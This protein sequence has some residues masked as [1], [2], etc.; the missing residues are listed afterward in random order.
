MVL[1]NSCGI[2]AYHEFFIFNTGN[3]PFDPTTINTS[4]SNGA[5]PPALPPSASNYIGVG[6]PAV[7]SIVAQLNAWAGCA[8]F[9]VAPNPIPPNSPVMAFNSSVAASAPGGLSSMT[10]IPNLSSYCGRTTYVV[11]GN[12]AGAA[13]YF[14]NTQ[15]GNPLIIKFGGC[16]TTITYGVPISQTDGTYITCAGNQV[17]Q[18]NTGA[19]CFPPGCVSPTLTATVSGGPCVTPSQTVNFTTTTN[20]P[21]GSTYMWTGPNGYNSTLANP[22]VSG[23]PAGN[24]IF[25]VK[26]IAPGGCFS[27]STV[28]VTVSPAFNFTPLPDL[29]VCGNS[30]LSLSVGGSPGPSAGAGYLWNGAGLSSIFA[31][32]PTL[33]PQLPVSPATGTTN[34]YSVTITE[35]NGCRWLDTFKLT[36]VPMPPMLSVAN[37]VNL[38]TGQALNL[39][40]NSATMNWNGPISIPSAPNPKLPIPVKFTWTG[41]NGFTTNQTTDILPNLTSVPGAQIPGVGGPYIYKLTPSIPGYSHP[42]CSMSPIDVT[43]NVQP[44]GSI[45]LAPT[46]LCQGQTVDLT[47]LITSPSP[48][49]VGSWTGTGVG[50]SPT[51]NAG[52]LSPGSYS[53]TFT[54]SAAACLAATSTNVS[55]STPPNVTLSQSGTICGLTAPFSGQTAITATAGFTTY[56]WSTGVSGSGNAVTVSAPGTYTVTVTNASGCT[57]V[58]SLT[59]SSF[60]SP[61]VS[62]TGPGSLCSGVNATL[63]LNSSFSSYLW[64]DN[65]TASSLAIINPGTYSVTVTDNNGCSATTSKTIAAAA[66][67]NPTF[68]PFGKICG[69]GSVLLSLTGIFDTYSWSNGLGNGAAVTVNSG[70]SYSVTVSNTA[71]GCTAVATATVQQFPNPTV[72]ITG[73]LMFCFGGIG[74]TLSASPANF[75]NYQWSNGS[76]S[77]STTVTLAQNYSLTVTDINGCSASVSK[78][79]SYFPSP[80]PSITGSTSICAGSSTTLDAGPGFNSYLWSTGATGQTITT[81]QPGFVS[82]SVTDSK[83]CI[84]TDV[85]NII[86][87]GSLAFNISGNTSFCDGLSSTLNAGSGFSSYLWSTGETTQAIIVT[88]SNTYSV[89]VSNGSCTGNSSVIVTK[90]SLPTVSITGNASFCEGTTS[91]LSTNI[92]FSIYRWSTGQFTQSI[93]VAAASTY[94]VTVQDINGC[95]ATNQITITS[96][97][98][99]KPIIIGKNSIC[100]GDTSLLS[101][102]ENY[103]AYKWSD[104]ST[105]KDLAAR[106]FTSYFVTVTALN[107]CTGSTSFLLSK[108]PDLKPQITGKKEFCENDTLHLSVN[109]AFGG[110][111]WSSGQS[112]TGIIINKGGTYKVTV[113]NGACKGVDSIQVKMNPLPVLNTSKDTALCAGQSVNFSVQTGYASYLWSTGETGNSISSSTSG[114]YYVNVKD[115]KGCT[116]RDSVK[117]VVNPLPVP[118]IVGQATICFGEKT[119]LSLSEKY[120]AYRWSTGK[121]SDTIE[122]NQPGKYE[123]SVTDNN[124]CINSAS[125]DVDVK[126]NLNPL[127][128]GPTSF[129]KGDSVV[130]GL[131]AVYASYK[132]SDQ[133][134]TPEI[135]VNKAGKYSVTV[136]SSSGCSGSKDITISENPNPA[137][138]ITG[139]LFICGSR[140]T[141]LDAGSGYNTYLW[142]NGDKAQKTNISSPGKY[143]VT[144]TTAA[145]CKGS[146]SAFLQ[147]K[148]VTGSLRDTICKSDFRVFN[149]NRYD[150]S[151]SSGTE[152]LIGA[153]GGGCDSILTIQLFFRPDINIG[154]DGDKTVCSASPVKLVLN[155]TGYNGT[156]NAV[157]EDSDGGKINLTNVKNGDTL[158]VNP[159]K[160]KIYRISAVSI[161]NGNCTLVLGAAKVTVSPIEISTQVSQITCSG[162]NNGSAD[163]QVRK[164]IPPFNYSWDFGASTAGITDLKT[165]VYKF[166][167]TDAIGCTASADISINEP[168]PISATLSSDSLT[169]NPSSG[170]ITIDSI[171]GGSGNFVYS[172]DGTIFNPIN[173]TPFK[174][175]NLGAGNY[176]V[177]IREATADA[178]NWSGNINVAQGKALTVNLGPDI[179]LVY[180]DSIVLTP[181]T[182][183]QMS[184]I[185]WTPATYLNCDTCQFTISKPKATSN[186]LV[187]VWDENGCLATDEV[188]IIVNQIRR[189][190]IP[191]VFSPNVDGNNDLFRIYL[192]DETVKV[193]YFRILDRWGELMYEDL[194]F[195]KEDALDDRRGWNGYFRGKL[196]NPGVYIYSAQVEFTDGETKNYTG[197]FMLLKQ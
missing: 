149:G 192:G 35:T 119:I 70:Q 52:V 188:Q 81:N 66:P 152:T 48:A 3:V 107:G 125:K 172:I 6:N 127:I 12:Y 45:T 41:P 49:P 30:P 148:N 24:N 62:V 10:P 145:G 155:V 181:V 130:L 74:T 88:S 118:T 53:V 87:S 20:A 134:A 57:A 114:S 65:S 158:T 151:K 157:V 178:C 110:Y 43:V 126:S 163:I 40:I 95:T 138:L 147:L 38:C 32:S 116:N 11:A 176:I 146:N 96:A 2:E 67:L 86:N 132:W 80:T 113:N 69:N 173:V 101:L 72:D 187:K 13:D 21:A 106:S 46:A 54:P 117:L 197:D 22:S 140:T 184:K 182:N 94:S 122:I 142:S 150:F 26:V 78:L 120:K 5:P 19:G 194:N 18:Y 195:T 59:V 39:N 137:P 154:F 164:G 58:K 63:T 76:V 83:G 177:T 100:A 183:F 179:T 161:A 98:S 156:F 16:T 28:T 1:V 56:N 103:S 77:P 7:P 64:N 75:A 159:D 31:P 144:V 136:T 175:P 169:C 37:P 36:T 112:A 165:G 139:N 25:K 82:V 73:N 131:D 61:N 97:V 47:T 17:A 91:A 191:N 109:G 170:S 167:V 180:G 193:N 123:I 128:T 9:A 29:T 190:F 90:N 111:K 99:P 171:K 108:E 79:T 14:K 196:L 44:G 105:K 162:K 84:G 23:L 68:S 42:S 34:N 85:K 55:I 186:Y 124:G 121:A 160:T 115:A 102:T 50:P 189:V 133:Q 141:T 51:F 27:M 168:L 174:I 4:S 89:T 104:G 185:Q 143:T 33:T 71:T 15:S 153:A 8:A 92:P 93:N 129:C 135:T 166:T 60:A